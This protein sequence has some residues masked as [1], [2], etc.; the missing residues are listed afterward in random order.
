MKQIG[1][2]GRIVA[3][4]L[5]AI[6]LTAIGIIVFVRN[7]VRNTALNAMVDKAASV[8][9]IAEDIRSSIGML[10][11]EQIV[12]TERLFTEA[13]AATANATTDAERLRIAQTLDVYKAIPIVRSWQSVQRNAEELDVEFQVLSQSPRN[14]RNQATGAAAEILREMGE[15]GQLEFYRVEPESNVLRYIRTIEVEE[16]C[17]ICH[18]DGDTDVLGFSM[19]G[20]TVGEQRGAFQ[21]EF[22]L[23]ETDR[24]VAAVMWQ[25]ALATAIM[26]VLTAVILQTVVRRLAV[27]PVRTIRAVAE[28]IA[29]GDLQVEI[30]RHAVND[31]IGKLKTAMSEMAHNLDSVVSAVRDT[32][33]EVALISRQVRESAQQLSDG[34]NQ[35][36]A[37]IEEISSSMEQTAA[38]VRANAED[39]RETRSIARRVTEEVE[40]SGTAVDAAAA[41]MEAIAERIAVIDEIAH[42]TNLL[43]LNAAI[44]AARAGKH[45]AGFAVVAQEVRSLADRSRSAAAEIGELTRT[46]V[47]ATRAAA[48]SLRAAVPEVRKTAGLVQRIS[49][50]GDEQSH[51][52]EQIN[53]AIQQLDTVVQRNASF[54]EELAATA[55][56][57]DDQA[58]RLHTELSFF[59]TKQQ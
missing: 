17:L 31:D 6:L 46:N 29:D 40:Q 21:F 56:E 8:S 48:D 13:R 30:A 24:E 52:I 16:G 51:G 4:V 59:R 35:Q 3:V 14:P 7:E 12:D 42:R 54:S 20:M 1:F 2:G 36:A 53:A 15:T 26:A 25:I 32:E 45:G 58:G 44:E 23:A 57:L 22:S 55:E 19:E 10:W 34:S 49:D 9:L 28:R 39:S 18:G 33:G 38:S 43:S 47:Q 5:L 41:A 11:D 27:A 50:A 37:N